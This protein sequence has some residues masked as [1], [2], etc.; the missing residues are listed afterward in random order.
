MRLFKACFISLLL[1]S[2]ASSATES[3]VTKNKAIAMQLYSAAQSIVLDAGKIKKSENSTLT[4]RNLNVRVFKMEET[5]KTLG[6]GTPLDG[7]FGQC[8]AM[9]S[10]LHEYID[11]AAGEPNLQKFKFDFY[12][13][14]EKGCRDQIENAGK[15]DDDDVAIIDV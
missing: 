4:R 13:S 10:A 5:A 8:I 14:R 1:A 6:S 11:A 3:D 15:P 9:T 12:R 2:G 7:Q